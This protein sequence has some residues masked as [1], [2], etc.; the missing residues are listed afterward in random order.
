MV[1]ET[2]RL[3][4]Y[5]TTH[6]RKNKHESR[7]AIQKR[8]SGYKRRQLRHTDAQRRVMDMTNNN[9]RWN[10]YCTTQTRTSTSNRRR[11][12]RTNQ[13][14]PNKRT[15]SNKTVGEKR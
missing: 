5:P 3:Q 4:L 9:L 1:L 14:N 2:T 12:T 7:H 8:E 11:N 10:V 13:K 15:R 6:P